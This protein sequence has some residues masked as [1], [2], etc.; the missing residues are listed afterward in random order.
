VD[1]DW[2][3]AITEFRFVP[4]I[5]PAERV[6]TLY[7]KDGCSDLDGNGMQE[8]RFLTYTSDSL[9]PS[10]YITFYIDGHEEKP[11]VVALFDSMLE[12]VR[13]EVTDRS[14]LQMKWLP[15][16]SYTALSGTDLDGDK[17]FD[18]T[19]YSQVTV[20]SVGVPVRLDLADEPERWKIL[21]RLEAFF[22]TDRGVEEFD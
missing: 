9:M 2:N 12:L 8:W 22:D 21:D 19:A 13:M 10:G 5:P 11:T 16:A 1:V 20:D 18:L 4:R 3:A 6:Y 15:P 17:R 14:T 7:L